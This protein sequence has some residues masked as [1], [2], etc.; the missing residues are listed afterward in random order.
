[1]SNQFLKLRRSAVPG[2]I[3]T[4]S[5]LEFGEIALN[6]YD[7][8]A[9][10]KKSGSNGEE[11]VI[12]GA[13]S[14]SFTGS[15]FGTASYSIFAATSSYSDNIFGERF[16][17][18]VYTGQNTLSTGSIYDSGSF[19]GIGTS[20]PNNPDSVERLLVD[21]GQ[22]D[23]FNLI[24]GQAEID[25]YLQFN[26][27]NAFTGATASGDFVVTNDA[28]TEN[29]NYID[30]GINSSV[31]DPAIGV[32]GGPNDAY[33]FSTGRDLLIGN[34]TSGSRVVIFNGGLDTETYAKIYIHPE[35]ITGFNTST[36]ASLISAEVP[37]IRVVPANDTTYNI[38]QSE[39]DI[40]NYLQ[41]NIQNLN[42]GSSASTDIVA[43]NDI[44][45]ETDYYIDM[46]VNSSGYDIPN[47]VG[48]ASD[49][50]LYSTAN[51]LHIGNAS[52]GMPVMFF[53]GGLDSE[54]NRKLV[55]NADGYHEV[56]GSINASA[57]FT[58]SLHGTASWA[59]NA[60]TASSADNFVVR[61]N[62]T[63]SNALF[64]GT[65]TAQTLV[66]QTVTSSVDFVTGSTRFGTQLTDTHQFTGSVSITGSL[67]VS[68]PLNATS[69]WATNAL[70]ASY[71]PS[72]AIVGDF[73]RI[74]T[75][76]VTA[77]VD[78]GS[79]QVVS[80]SIA[81]LSVNSQ[82]GMRL[83]TAGTIDRSSGAILLNS[84]SLGG[85]WVYGN[86]RVQAGSLNFNGRTFLEEDSSQVLAQRSGLVSQSFRIYNT[87]TSLSNFERG[88]LEWSGS[89]FNIGTEQSG[90]GAARD[91]AL[92]TS[93]STR[94]FISSSGRIGI[95]RDTPSYSLDVS[96]SV[97][98]GAITDVTTQ[99]ELL[100]LSVGSSAGSTSHIGFQRA[101]ATYA[102]YNLGYIG[103]G[104]F[105]FWRTGDAD[106][107]FGFNSSTTGLVGINFGLANG[108]INA[109]TSFY[110]SSA[111]QYTAPIRLFN[112]TTSAVGVYLPFITVNST[113]TTYEYA[114][115][116]GIKPST[117]AGTAVV[118]GLQ[119]SIKSGS[120]SWINAF[121]ITFDSRFLM[122]GSLSLSGSSHSIVGQTT[123]NNLTGSLFGTASWA[124][125]AVTASYVPSTAVVGDFSR[126][127]TGSVTASVGIGTASFQLTSGSSTFL[128]VSSSGNVGVNTNEP[129]YRLD[130]KGTALLQGNTII[131]GSS[132][133][134]LNVQRDGGAFIRTRAINNNGDV[135]IQFQGAGDRGS[136]YGNA[137]YRIH[138]EPNAEFVQS[139]I[140][141][142]PKNGTGMNVGIGLTN[143]SA[144]LHVS[145]SALTGSVLFRVDGPE[146][147]NILYVTASG[148]V[149]IGYATTGSLYRLD[150]SGSIRTTDQLYVD[151]ASIDYQQ[152]LSV[153][154]GSWQTVV[155]SPTGSYR[156]AFFDYVLFS[157]SIGRSGTVTTFWSASATEF[158][159]NYTEDLG[160]STAG[161]VLQTAISASQIVLQATA[162]SAAWTIRSLTRL[163]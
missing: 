79:F 44:G 150:V 33:L 2:K 163:L 72:T 136:I 109:Q 102:S 126:I 75:G 97:R 158:Y 45:T 154:T 92:Q 145:S 148:Q 118:G 128:F 122:T 59:L 151:S 119:F 100:R 113:G 71:V 95:N 19:T 78:T 37:A 63:G 161:V 106:S 42:S 89:T 155:A 60:F 140:I 3:P 7:G 64:T 133:Y 98:I 114:K 149:G 8:L 41:N 125:N 91:L 32:V 130:V 53:A 76:S 10:I 48:T 62:L 143:P 46:G 20:V 28:G 22:T 99:G 38:I 23:S 141:M 147:K 124:L 144:R 66:V 129:L 61:G 139:D 86:L 52:A 57:G 105:G 90:S 127:A 11:I 88:K 55:L 146:Q 39:G 43:T 85:T 25:N 74:A 87:Y 117:F 81:L 1:M 159:E 112:N 13:T 14:G 18:A 65:V 132:I 156:A 116:T 152:N 51:H 17:A 54:A 137:S 160:G 138:I 111:S 82:G 104:N 68:G 153:Q 142:N 120:D 30:F 134:A 47:S 101:N 21:A 115:I 29:E 35:G 58:G 73:S 50:Y 93:G 110:F 16:Y 67:T 77:S 162:S 121:D 5:S 123:I 56:T 9:F 131:S 69:S 31:Y 15:L 135:G 96:G 26:L 70:T 84:T 49:A 108:T 6:T 107:L 103:T 34:A 36:T 83:G 80:S 4:T 27:R 40:D 157:G 24:I 94:L 12:I